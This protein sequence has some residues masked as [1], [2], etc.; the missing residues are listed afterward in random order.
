MKF[1]CWREIFLMTCEPSSGSTFGAL[2]LPLL[3]FRWSGALLPPG[4]S[5]VES[6]GGVPLNCS[7]YYHGSA[8]TSCERVCCSLLACRLVLQMKCA[9]LKVPA[10]CPPVAMGSTWSAVKLSLC[11]YFNDLSIGSLH[12]QHVRLGCARSRARLRLY[13]G[14]LVRDL[15]CIAIASLRYSCVLPNACSVRRW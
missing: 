5:S 2:P 10:L 15:L 13:S 6:P 1:K 4:V 8:W 12:S 11:G 14:S 7:V 3:R 9:G